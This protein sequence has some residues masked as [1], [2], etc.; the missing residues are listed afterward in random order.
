MQPLGVKDRDARGRGGDQTELTQ[1]GDNLGDGGAGGAN[2]LGQTLL[3]H[4]CDDTSVVL[5]DS[6]VEEVARYAL[7]QG[8][9]GPVSDGVNG[10]GQPARRLTREQPADR[11]LGL[12]EMPEQAGIEHEQTRVRDQLDADGHGATDDSW[13]P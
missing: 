8:T 1:F 13:D 4:R 2:R 10:V 3:R 9:K 11:R 5:T 12:A 6:E 7:P